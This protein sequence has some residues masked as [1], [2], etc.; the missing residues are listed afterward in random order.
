MEERL[1]K[2]L[3][4]KGICSRREA[5]RWIE[6]G[7]VKVDGQVAH[8][9][10][11]V[12]LEKQDVVVNGKS[13]NRLQMARTVIAV[14]KPVGYTCS[15][16]DPYAE[17]LV[18]ELLPKHFLKMKLFVAGRLD[19]DSSGLTII[20]N[21]GD[22]GYQLTHPSRN[23][24]KRYSVVFTPQLERKDF[25]F[26]TDGQRVDGEFLKFERILTPKVN[27]PGPFTQLD[28][29]LNHG[30]K[31]EIRRLF[32]HSGREVKKLQRK[33]IGNYRMQ[34][35]P[36]GGHRVLSERE[37]ESLLAGSVYKS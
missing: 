3:S 35:I 26:F 1:Q 11:K 29:V 16:Q 25:R 9:G 13:I 24:D 31:R 10:Q 34:R 27:A 17:K 2:I 12:D 21:D 30:K 20:T 8:V 15:N 18:F 6:D 32:E 19:K 23:V 33:S 22:L 14:N 36:P 37:I 5:E 4:Q 7:R 28:V